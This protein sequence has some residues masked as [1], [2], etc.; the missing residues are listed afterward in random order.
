MTATDAPHR[1]TLQK[2][3]DIEGIPY[4]LSKGGKVR[5]T[6]EVLQYLESKVIDSIV[7]AMCSE[8][9]EVEPD[10]TCPHGNPSLLISLGLI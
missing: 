9:C 1:I 2:L 8:G 6:D 10:G 3:L 5:Q 7:P 4:T